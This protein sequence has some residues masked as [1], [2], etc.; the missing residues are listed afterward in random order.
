MGCGASKVEDLPLVTLCRERKELVKAAS[1][2]RYAL[3]AAHVSYF[4]S[5]KDVGDAFRRFVDEE[6]VIGVSSPLDSPVLKLPS[7]K[8]KTKNK[9]KGND[10]NAVSR[11]SS[12]SLSIS[13]S[14]SPSHLHSLD[15]KEEE[16]EDECSHLH[17]SSDSDSDLCSSSSG[18]IRMEK[19]T[20]MEEP[21][22]YYEPPRD[23]SQPGVNSYAYFMKKSS[24]AMPSVIYEEPQP[25]SAQWSDQHSNYPQSNYP[26]YGNGG[27]FGFS[28]GEPSHDAYNTG[29]PSHPV[30]PPAPP[31]PNVSAWDFLNPFYSYDS[32]YTGYYSQPRYGYGSISSSPDSKEVREREGIPE[33]EEETDQGV[34]KE[35]P[36]E[37]KLSSENVN[38]SSSEGTSMA[39]PVHNKD[40]AEKQDA[41]FSGGTGKEIES[42][43]D[44]IVSKRP[45]EESPGKNEVNF[46]EDEPLAQEIESTEPSTS[47]KLSTYGT[48]DLQEV[49]RE[50]RDEFESASSY[51][52]DVALMLEVGKLPYHP[53]E[54][55]LKVIFSR[56]LYFISSFVSSSQPPSRRSVGLASSTMKMAKTY[57]RDPGRSNNMKHCTLSS[58]LEKLYVW[59]KKL[60]KEVKDEERLRVVYERRCKRLRILDD[61]GAESN[62]IEATQASIQKLLTKINVCLGAIDAIS[63]RI[64][65]LR[66]EE[67]QPQLNELIIGL[68][69]MWRSMLKCHQKQFEAI[70]N[71]KI[72]TLKAHTGFPR[73][74]SFAATVELESQLL[75]WCTRFSDWVNA[76]KSYAESLNGWLL[77]CLLQE[78]EETSDGLAPFSPGRAG[79]PPVFVICNDWKQAIERISDTGVADAMQ[80][81]ARSLHQ[82][83]EK[84]DEE[85]RQRLKA[86]YISKDFEK[87]LQALRM[88]RGRMKRNRVAL[89][90]TTLG[91]VHTESGVSRLDDLKVDLDSMRKRLEEERIRHKEAVKLVHSAASSSIQ[92]GL[93]PIFEALANFTSEILK[94]YEQVRI[95]RTG[96][97]S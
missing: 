78:P 4:R 76:Q 89:S 3:A 14:A 86:E 56:I 43:P 46:G 18:H 71:S 13:H 53:R 70:M 16:E 44:T 90:D 67:L 66:D 40:Q 30:E 49:V 19:I 1:E 42:S 54:T 65:K 5:L 57:Y 6:F 82:L 34:F 79:A 93:I 87:Q 24:T 72:R 32:G 69:R 31:S 50:I 88:E 74:S 27:F 10:I 85:N 36:K 41:E 55:A 61:R 62:K 47:T 25:V 35:I 73:D 64:H 22:S 58:T 17:L 81:F 97:G 91:P 92:A 38:K 95:Q 60:Y 48:R 63:S 21:H 39:A 33:L 52:K 94:A 80:E 8:G 20:E 28:T 23:W 51:G 77:G 83:W 29:Q 75:K 45:G 11:S 2:H 84:Q 37:K 12:S 7:D 59:E 9:N 96:E 68:T 26:Q 15:E